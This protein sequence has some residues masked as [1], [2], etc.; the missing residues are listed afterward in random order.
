MI[1]TIDYILTFIFGW[2]TGGIIIWII[3]LPDPEEEYVKLEDLMKEYR[4]DDNR[5]QRRKKNNSKSKSK[6]RH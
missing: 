3:M 5:Q 1:D 6:K 2:I 4:K